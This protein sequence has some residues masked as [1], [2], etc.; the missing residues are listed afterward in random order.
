MK[1]IIYDIKQFL[2]KVKWWI[3]YKLLNNNE[4]NLFAA[5]LNR[6]WDTLEKY[7]NCLG[8]TFHE[9][10]EEVYKMKTNLK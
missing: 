3:I 10:R 7:S 5:N 2:I 1:N 8:E 9:F 6:E 4:R